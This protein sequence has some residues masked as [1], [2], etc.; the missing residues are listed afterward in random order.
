MTEN[1]NMERDMVEEPIGMLI[2]IVMMDIGS[3]V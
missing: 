1:G 3:V 2:V